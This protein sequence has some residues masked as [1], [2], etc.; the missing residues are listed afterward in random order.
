M[1][2]Y[3]FA[4]CLFW[5]F[6][7]CQEPLK[8]VPVVVAETVNEVKEVKEVKE[9]NADTLPPKPPYTHV[10]LGQGHALAVAIAGHYNDPRAAPLKD[11]I[12]YNG[13]RN[14][15]SM[16]INYD[17][18]ENHWHLVFFTK[19]FVSSIAVDSIKQFLE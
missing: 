17:V 14:T 11:V 12:A 5:L 1:K 9:V 16:R 3:L 2:F 18:F 6:V 15:Q 7:A 19:D 4:V 8:P 13:L 10:K